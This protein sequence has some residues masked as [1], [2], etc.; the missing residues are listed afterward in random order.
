[1]IEAGEVGHHDCITDTRR[2][3]IRDKAFR[4]S[5]SSKQI[6]AEPNFTFRF[7]VGSRYVF[8]RLRMATKSAHCWT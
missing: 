5:K 8:Y 3:Q 4:H 6:L 1:M 7:L 2:I